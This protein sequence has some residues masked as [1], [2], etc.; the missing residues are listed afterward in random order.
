M[1]KLTNVDYSQIK[2]GK[3]LGRGGYGRVI[4]A[5]FKGREVAVKIHPLELDSF[6]DLLLVG[7][8]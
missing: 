7:N 1:T 3:E 8:R 4:Q 2:E 5:V 6:A